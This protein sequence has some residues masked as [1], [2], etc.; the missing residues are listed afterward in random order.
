VKRP[1]ATAAPPSPMTPAAPEHPPSLRNTPTVD[2]ERI[3]AELE[4]RRAVASPIPEFQLPAS[5]SS[6]LS[7][8]QTDSPR[9]YTSFGLA[10]INP[11][12]L[13]ADSPLQAGTLFH[14]AADIGQSERQPLGLNDNIGNIAFSDDASVVPESELE[15][16]HPVQKGATGQQFQKLFQLHD[17]RK[18]IDFRVRS[19]LRSRLTFRRV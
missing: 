9:P 14:Y 16:N 5:G 4:R 15:E 6:T 8:R 3:L 12:L 7:F 18:Y 19:S 11:S 10:T 1:R 2:L 17:K 13:Q